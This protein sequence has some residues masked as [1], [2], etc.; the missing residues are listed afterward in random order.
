MLTASDISFLLL[1][2][3]LQKMFCVLDQDSFKADSY[4]TLSR[5]VYKA[6]LSASSPLT[7]CIVEI[8]ILG[9]F[10]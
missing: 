9:S 1:W 7:L 6:T 4:M 3:F 10:L 8:F 5:S 2:L